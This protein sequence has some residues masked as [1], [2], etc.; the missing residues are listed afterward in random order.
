MKMKPSTSRMSNDKTVVSKICT[1]LIHRD[2]K[3]NI[4]NL[5]KIKND[6]IKSTITCLAFLFLMFN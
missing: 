5:E 4:C 6:R 2:L 1:G 3:P